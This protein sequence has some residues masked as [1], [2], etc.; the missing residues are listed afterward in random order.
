MEASGSLAC[1]LSDSFLV[2]LSP[3]LV[4]NHR[5]ADPASSKQ[6]CLAFPEELVPAGCDQWEAGKETAEGWGKH[7]I[8]H[9][10]PALKSESVSC[11][12]LSESVTPWT[13][14][15]QAPLSHGILQARI[16]EW[17]AIPFSRGSSSPRYQTDSL[18]SG[19]PG[20]PKCLV[21][22]DPGLQ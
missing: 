16:L 14:A 18:L 12:V 6:H 10:P 20:K 19:P 21:T 1:V 17:V 9:L 2:L 11:S 22:L 15:H 7:N 5:G 8:P 13:V 4:C 3:S